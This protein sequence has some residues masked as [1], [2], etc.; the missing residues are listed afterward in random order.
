[1]F[2][3][4]SLNAHRRIGAREDVSAGKD[5]WWLSDGRG[6][7]LMTKGNVSSFQGRDASISVHSY[8]LRLC[9]FAFAFHTTLIFLHRTFPSFIVLIIQLMA[10]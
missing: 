6:A 7:M 8:A 3:F 2:V 10:R 1:M 4:N 5:D 9:H